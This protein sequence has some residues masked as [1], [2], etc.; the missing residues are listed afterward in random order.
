MDLSTTNFATFYLKTLFVNLSVKSKSTTGI[1]SGGY[2][3]TAGYDFTPSF[4]QISNYWSQFTAPALNTPAFSSAKS[5]YSCLISS[6]DF[7]S[8]FL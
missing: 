2:I 1:G 8:S 4:W 7:P 6:N 3:L 5:M